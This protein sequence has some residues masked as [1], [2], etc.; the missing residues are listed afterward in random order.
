MWKV[1]PRYFK[2]TE[3]H[4]GLLLQRNIP[5]SPIRIITRIGNNTGARDFTLLDTSFPETP[6]IL[7][8]S[9]WAEPNNSTASLDDM[10]LQFDQYALSASTR[11]HGAGSL[12][13][14]VVWN[15]DLSELIPE[16]SMTINSSTGG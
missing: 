10:T 5:T 4:H 9:I 13:P 15:P 11:S 12:C 8:R 7:G 2:S 6:D 1:H 16:A 14:E 3:K